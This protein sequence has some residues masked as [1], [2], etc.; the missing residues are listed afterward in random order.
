MRPQTVT[1]QSINRTQYRLTTLIEANALTT[2]PCRHPV[3]VRRNMK[4]LIVVCW[5]DHCMCSAIPAS[6]IVVIVIVI[7]VFVVDDKYTFSP[8]VY[9]VLF[10]ETDTAYRRLSVKAG[11][12]RL[13]VF[14]RPGT[15]VL[16]W[17]LTLGFGR[18]KTLAPLVHR[19]IVYCSMHARHI[20]QQK[21]CCRRATSLEQ[22]PT[23]LARRRH[24][25]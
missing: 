25:L 11:M 2:T 7:V 1:H 17:W 10:T 8:S 9:R 6:D 19:Q 3:G 12:F 18:S 13:L 21:L 23:T 22:P 5:C 24:Q 20:W 4:L 15:S 16:G 14:V